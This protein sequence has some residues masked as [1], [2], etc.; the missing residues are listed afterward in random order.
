MALSARTM[1]VLVAA[2]ALAIVATA[3]AGTLSATAATPAPPT[4]VRALPSALD[5]DVPYQGQTR[6]DPSPK[7]GVLAFAKLFSSHYRVGSSSGI[8]RACSASLSEHME[9]R[10]WD[11]MLNAAKPDQKA[12][13][14]SVVSWLVKADSS[15]RPGAMARRFG[16]MY[17]IWN[18]KMWRAYDP[19][20]GWTPYY[21]SS[22][23]TD[24]IHFSFTWDGAAGRTSWWTGVAT[25]SYLTGPTSTPMP[26]QS[27]GTQVRPPAGSLTYGM[28]SSA[29]RDLQ[30]RLGVTPDSG[31]FGPLTRAAVERFQRSHRLPVTGVADPKTLAAVKTLTKPSVSSV[32]KAGVVLKYGMSSDSVK[33]LQIKLGGLPA[34]GYFGPLTLAKVTAFQ[35]SKRLP[36]TGVVDSRTLL[37]LGGLG[38]GPIAAPAATCAG[39]ALPAGAATVSTATPLTAYKSLSLRAGCTGDAV[40][41]LQR[42]LGGLPVT[43]LYG[44]MTQASVTSF[45]RS[46]GLKATGVVDRATWDAIERRDYPLARYRNV[47]LRQGSRGS[48]VQ[49]VQRLLRVSPTGY[50]GPL[51]EAAVKKLQTSK[52]ISAI[53]IVGPRTWAALEALAAD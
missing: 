42:A 11:W 37:A 34:T 13:A 25:R 7:Q 40:R 6:C 10:A 38:S 22:P 14:D 17:I 23:H 53:G 16:I 43:G 45:Q 20:R 28:T 8:I 52:K 51:T 46:V 31:W 47:V 15:G 30:Q 26:T 12:I 2:P 48:A 1:P 18:R 36:V 33:R 29:V 35:K 44:S 32:P 50:F 5:V 21:G 49:A 19:E 24:H 4:P 27:P 39:V 3:S 41:V 9:G